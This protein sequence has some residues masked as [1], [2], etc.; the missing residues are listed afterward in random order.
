MSAVGSERSL[1]WAVLAALSIPLVA[2]ATA[3][4]VSDAVARANAH[5]LFVDVVA[6]E[7]WDT[8][9][10]GAAT[11]T[12]TDTG[13][14]VAYPCKTGAGGPMVIVVGLDGAAG[15][16]LAPAAACRRPPHPPS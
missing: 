9:A 2:C 11:A 3:A 6:R 16:S 1:R 7:H 8:A 14:N 4:P 12:A 15:Y 5:Q 13:W 10:F